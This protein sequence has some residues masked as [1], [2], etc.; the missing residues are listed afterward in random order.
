M[1]K[2]ELKH[3]GLFRRSLCAVLIVSLC[4][5][6]LFG[7]EGVDPIELPLEDDSVVSPQPEK[8]LESIEN[9][10][11]IQSVGFAPE[12]NGV[13][14]VIDKATLQGLS[15]HLENDFGIQVGYDCNG[16][17]PYLQVFKDGQWHYVA[18]KEL[19][20]TTLMLGTT[21]GLPRFLADQYYSF[22]WI[23]SNDGREH[24][25]GELEPGQ[26]CF[27]LELRFEIPGVDGMPWTAWESCWLTTEFEISYPPFID[28]S[29]IPTA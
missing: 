12:Y 26:Y 6:P 7:C 25:Y 22:S 10:T 23:A 3:T 2:E 8:S 17:Y 19:I 24:L 9:W 27:V 16:A 11:H 18:T 5:I 15:L 20:F 4:C 29:N 21:P 14:I 28:F 13:R 1:K